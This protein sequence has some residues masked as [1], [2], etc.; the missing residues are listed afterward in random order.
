M[1]PSA[2]N[3]HAFLQ[4]CDNGCPDF[5][6][7]PRKN[8]N[9]GLFLIFLANRLTKFIPSQC[10][11]VDRSIYGLVQNRLA[12]P[13]HRGILD[14]DRKTAYCFQP[15]MRQKVKVAYWSPTHRECASSNTSN[16][17]APMA[18]STFPS[19]SRNPGLSGESVQKTQEAR[20]EASTISHPCTQPTPDR[21]SAWLTTNQPTN[22]L[23][24][25]LTD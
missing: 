12:F 2:S 15:Q 23:T 8:E 22:P 9:D 16:T 7:A 6:K 3:P 20:C 14:N 25:W 13:L 19:Y 5:E 1:W 18:F 4:C 24:D 17:F 10:T 21:N 11:L